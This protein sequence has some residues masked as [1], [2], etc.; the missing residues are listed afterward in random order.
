MVA[1]KKNKTKISLATML[2]LLTFKVFACKKSIVFIT[3]IVACAPMEWKKRTFDCRNMETANKNKCWI[4]KREKNKRR[5]SHDR[6][7]YPTIS[8]FVLCVLQFRHFFCYSLD[9][10]QFFRSRWTLTSVLK[11]WMKAAICNSVGQ[12]PFKCKFFGFFFVFIWRVF[13]FS[14]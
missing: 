10:K 4:Q 9:G 8:C 3:S 11:G 12:F 13:Y 2:L 6:I 7:A 5:I 1:R 14:F